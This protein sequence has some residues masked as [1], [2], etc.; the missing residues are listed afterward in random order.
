MPVIPSLHRAMEQ[1][2]AEGI[3]PA[4][5]LCVLHRGQP[6]HRSSHG[7]DP[8]GRR[9]QDES[10]FDLASLTKVMATTVCAAV[11][12]ERLELRLDDEVSAILG[13]GPRSTIRALLAHASGLPAWEPLFALAMEDPLARGIYPRGEG[14]HASARADRSSLEREAFRRSRELV[15]GAT[16]AHRPGPE[17]GHRLYSDL[18]FILLGHVLER[19]GQ[20]RLDRLCEQLVWRP[21]GLDRLRFFDLERGQA[22]GPEAHVLPTG[23]TRPRPPAPGQEGSYGVPAQ[24]ERVR[25]GRVDDDNAYALGGVAGHAGLFGTASCVARFGWCIEEELRGAG[26]LDAAEALRVFVRR[27]EATLGSP[28]GLGFDLPSGERSAAG[29]SLG[30]LGPLSAFG[31]LGFTGTSLWVDRDRELSVALLS[32]RVYPTRESTLIRAFRPSIHDQI[33]AAIAQKSP[34]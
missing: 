12:V 2:L 10:L 23:R 7:S 13:Q 19:V 11:L 27:D 3:F 17:E 6:V 29:R 9:V 33:V 8:R 28:R 31:H 5:Q 4:A 30:R 16:L 14:I 32:N 18:G 25:P 20:A 15:L 34:I 22:P 21:L 1:A 26:R 24:S